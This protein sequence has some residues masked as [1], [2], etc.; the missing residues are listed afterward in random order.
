MDDSGSMDWN[1][2]VSGP[3][4]NGGFVLSNAAVASSRVRS[5]TYTY[6]WD[7]S[8]NAYSITSRYGRVLPTEEALQANSNTDNN[9]YGVWRARNPLH[10]RAY[11]NRDVQYVPWIGNDAVNSD[12]PQADPNNIR[13]DPV[14]P[15]NLFD[16]LAPHSYTSFSVPDWDNNG[17]LETVAVNN[18]Y[19]PRY[20]Y[21]ASPVPLAW[22][23]PHTLVEIR[24]GSGPFP[25]DMWPGSPDRDD[26]A[27]GDNDPLDC[28]YAQEIQ[29]FANWF[30]YY[31]SREYVAKAGVG[32]VIARVQ[33]IRVGYETIRNSVSEPVR[34][35]NEHYYEGNKKLLLDDIYSVNSSGGTPLRRLLERAGDIFSCQ[36][37][38]CPALPAPDGF[39]QQN[40]ALLF[41]D[42]YWNGGTAV[43][44]NRDDDGA[45]PYDGG[46]YADTVSSTL[47]D[48]AMHYYETD[49]HP[50][51]DD[52][53]AVTRRDTLGA[54]PA[55]FPGVVKVMHQHM[56]TYAIAFG[57]SGTIDPTTVPSN[58]LTPFAWTNPFSA[59]LHKI[60]DMLHAATNGR[61]SFLNAGNP[62]QLELAFEQAFLEFTQGSSS[63]SAAAFNSTSLQDG[64]LLYRG[65]YDLR[66]NTGEL[67][68]TTVNPDGTLAATPVWRAADRLNPVYKLPTARR[69]VT[70]DRGLYDGMPFRFASLSPDQQLTI[71]SLEVEYVRG[72][73]TNELPTGNLRERPLDDGLLGDIVNSSPVFVGTPRG[74]N[75]D[76]APYPTSDLYSDFVTTNVSRTPVVYVGA[77]DG[78]LHGFNALTGDELFGYVPN[79]V[80]DATQAYHS[81]LDVFASPFYLHQYYVDLTPRLN[82]VYMR[83]SDSV[84]TRSWN[85]VLLGGLG[86]GGKGFFLLNVNDPDTMFASDANAA[87]S[88]LWE[89]TDEDDTY[90]VDGMGVPLGGAVGAITDPAGDP[91][92]DLGYALSLP[93][94]A[95]SNMG[96]GG[97]PEERAW[98]AIFGNG[99]NSTAGIAKLFVLNLEGGLDGW[100]PGDFTKIDTGI[101]VPLAPNPLEGFP[102][103][104]G[105][106]TAVDRDLNGTVDWVF[107]GDRLGNLYRFDMTDADPANWYSTRLFQ[108]TYDDGSTVLEQPILSRPLVVK[109]PTEDGFLIIFGTGSF[110]T[111]EDGTSQDVQSI[112]GIWDRGEASPATAIAGSK[113]DRLVQQI[114]TNVV[115]DAVSPP[116]TRR[117]VSRNPV[118]YTPE[119]GVPGTYGWYI[120]LDM[121]RAAT[122][123]S[124]V[125]NLDTSGQAPPAPQ[126]PGEKAVRRMLFRDGTVI[127]TTV[128]PAVGQASCF[129]ARPGSILLFDAL[130]GGDALSAV[131]DF[132]T[133]GVVDSGDLVSYGGE[134]YSGGMLFNQEDLDGS[135]VDLSTLGGEGATDWLFVSGGNETISYRIDDINDSRTGRLSWQLLETSN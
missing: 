106:T 130:S 46:R 77:N 24:V 125:G 105:S 22:D 124:G 37:G 65:F 120:D 43:S 104:L 17:G 117:I 84:I 69:L 134:S 34:Q 50:T 102:N 113:Q 122:T 94:V 9:E 116:I 93:T 58:P 6:L 67:M 33:D 126:F 41:S 64:T 82:D 101:G 7:L 89:F 27:V 42:G 5:R 78:I 87:Q 99:P 57:V 11:Y 16:L 28:T 44:G 10:N 36:T 53:V 39:C 60:D 121:V 97:A 100:G 74:F 52:I 91:V 14:D 109:H 132:N 13:L 63:T 70:F 111:K 45:G 66:N 118:N 25:G 81:S 73:R 8:V 75:R 38:T 114:I 90:P 80:L 112:Y 86:G 54:P 18:V 71:S 95:M 62:Q 83:A 128:L 107:A 26:C 47:A 96:N 119:G 110:M 49:M 48:V 3:D 129:G 127:T 123:L 103:G 55:T 32:G 4:Q 35:M 135:L 2:I 51:Y 20:Y 31:R 108:A 115:D 15:T 59:S 12:F 88:V 76:Q 61:G 1:M 131:I 98:V 21:T 56:K 79:K 19:L 23:D 40:F 85:S 72:I 68:A 30:M 133:D 92:K 29:N